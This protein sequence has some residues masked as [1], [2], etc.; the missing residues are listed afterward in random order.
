MDIGLLQSYADQGYTRKEIAELMGV[1]LSTVSNNC[2]RHKIKTKRPSMAGKRPMK[3]SVRKTLELRKTGLS[4]NE[5]ARLM[6]VPMERVANA[7]RDYGLGGKIIEQRLTESQVADYVSESGF[8]YVGGYQ[9]QNKPITVRCRTC[10][11]TFERLFHIFRDVATGHWNCKNECPLCKSDDNA[12][13]ERKRQEERE[14]KRMDAEREAQMKAQRKAEQLSRQVNEQLAK[15]LAIHVCRNCGTEFCIESTG[16][17]SEVSC[18]ERCQRR[19]HER[20]KNEKRMDKLKKR[21]HDT[22]ITLEKLYKRDAGV[23]YL[24]GRVCDWTDIIE[25]NGT[26]VAGDNYPSIDHVKPIAKNGTHT[27]D[28]IKL[29]CRACNTLKGWR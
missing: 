20:I 29:S 12:E 21:R 28:N 25:K 8:D 11:R 16:Y 4:Y 7:C 18:S 2:V 15:R 9:S 3:A 10:G 1:P 5:I 17:N 14:K 23:C 13:R 27:W 26:M 22:D 6:E 19:W 24:C